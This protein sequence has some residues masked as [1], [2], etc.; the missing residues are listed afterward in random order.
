MTTARA[1][2]PGAIT[3]EGL[4][5][6]LTSRQLAILRAAAREAKDWALSDSLR[7]VLGATG[8]T[9]RDTPTGPEWST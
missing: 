7:D 9:I 6:R 1:G 8:V 5:R 3:E 4:H 2:L